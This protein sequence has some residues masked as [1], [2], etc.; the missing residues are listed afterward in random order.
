MAARPTGLKQSSS[1]RRSSNRAAEPIAVFLRRSVP[2]PVE[3]L[4]EAQTVVGKFHRIGPDGPEH[5]AKRPCIWESRI[6]SR[7]HFGICCFGHEAFK[8]QSLYFA[9][10]L[11]LQYDRP[12]NIRVECYILHMFRLFTRCHDKELFFGQIHIKKSARLR[13]VI[14]RRRECHHMMSSDKRFDLINNFIQEASFF[15]VVTLALIFH[16]CCTSPNLKPSS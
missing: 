15:N 6:V 1:P 9:H 16:L 13:P 11:R 3:F 10:R 8:L 2:R 4:T 5:W 14:P 12:G 7:A